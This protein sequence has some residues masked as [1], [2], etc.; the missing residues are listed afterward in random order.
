MYRDNNASI[1]HLEYPNKSSYNQNLGVKAAIYMELKMRLAQTTTGMKKYLG[2]HWE[3]ISIIQVN[4]I[5]F[6]FVV[7][8]VLWARRLVFIEN[9]SLYTWEVSAACLCV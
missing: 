5:M 7:F 3:V 8:G 1:Y 6:F 2:K 4:S 9:V